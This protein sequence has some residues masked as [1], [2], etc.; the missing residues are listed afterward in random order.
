MNEFEQEPSTPSVSPGATWGA[1]GIGAGL[2]AADAAALPE[3]DKIK[4]WLNSKFPETAS[5]GKGMIAKHP[6][7]GEAMQDLKGIGEHSAL[8]RYLALPALGAAGVGLPVWAGARAA[9][10]EGGAGRGAGAGAGAGA[11]AG[12]LIPL[13]KAM[14][15]GTKGGVGSTLARAG[16]GAAAGAGGGALLG[17]AGGGMQ[18]HQREK[19][20]KKNKPEEIP[21]KAASAGFYEGVKQAGEEMS[22]GDARRFAKSLPSMSYSLMKGQNP[23]D[24]Q[25][26]RK[27][28][29]KEDILS[30]MTPEDAQRVARYY[31]RVAG[32]AF[33]ASQANLG[34][35]VGVGVAQNEKR[36]IFK[37]I[38]QDEIARRQKGR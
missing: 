37:S 2:G 17:A 29:R 7:M 21:S 15:F 16:V 36:E 27:A 9:K 10:D 8:R 6:I 35:G 25:T 30:S 26:L 12:A 5:K 31:H 22:R 33:W 20:E 1:A 28:L 32:P 23:R 19:A 18:K 14:I 4:A 13:L 3:L 38:L 24:E 34:L 11:A